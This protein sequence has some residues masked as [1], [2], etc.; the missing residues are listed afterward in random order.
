MSSPFHRQF[1][2][3]SPL[4][5]KDPNGPKTKKP[6][7]KPLGKKSVNDSPETDARRVR[8]YKAARLA[9]EANRAD[10]NESKRASKK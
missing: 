10:Y 6:T 5:Q 8:E 9:D 3:K 1:S 7:K 2:A 4:N